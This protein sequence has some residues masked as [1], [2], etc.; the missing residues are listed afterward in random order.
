MVQRLETASVRSVPIINS[1]SSLVV[2]NDKDLPPGS[3]QLRRHPRRLEVAQ[4][5]LLVSEAATGVCS[6]HC[7][8]WSKALQRSPTVHLAALPP[9]DPGK[10]TEEGAGN[11]KM[12]GR[13]E[14]CAF[15]AYTEVRSRAEITRSPFM[16]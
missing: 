10:D 1:R 11:E 15:A 6:S 14:D 16:R 2:A 9:K 7:R 13:R 3:G 4:I 8:E 12:E 5:R